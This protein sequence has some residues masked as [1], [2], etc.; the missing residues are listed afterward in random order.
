MDRMVRGSDGAHWDGCEESHWDCA[1][2]QKDKRI[3]ELERLNDYYREI[4]DSIREVL[5]GEHTPDSGEVQ[6]RYCCRKCG[7]P[8]ETRDETDLEN[9]SVTVEVLPCPDC[10]KKEGG[11]E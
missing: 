3:A 7:K 11:G 4:V 1:L 6:P 5:D 10:A 8:V 2:V 9:R